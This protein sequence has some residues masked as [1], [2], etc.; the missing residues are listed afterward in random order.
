MKIEV[1][2]SN[3][4]NF[5]D[6]DVFVSK[7]G[8][9][10]YIEFTGKGNGHGPA[11]GYIKL[12]KSDLKEILLKIQNPIRKDTPEYEERFGEDEWPFS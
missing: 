6:L 1:Y 4:H 12:S 3:G 10:Y 5:H 11:H 7:D 2:T 9:K 8:E